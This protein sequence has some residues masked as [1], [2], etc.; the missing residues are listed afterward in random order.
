MGKTYTAD[1]IFQQQRTWRDRVL[2]MLIVAVFGAPA[3]T[4]AAV[5]EGGEASAEG[6]PD[7]LVY[8]TSPYAI[9]VEKSTQRL[10]LYKA[11]S[12]LPKLVKTYPCSTGK[13]RGDKTES[14]DLKTPEGAYFFRM[15]HRDE[16]LPAKYGVMAFVLDFPNYIDRQ[17]GKGGNG[18]WLHGLDKPLLPFDTQGCVAMRNEDITDLSSYIRLYETPVLI[19]ETVN[20]VEP[21]QHSREV[22]EALQLVA[23][24]RKAWQGKDLQ[25]FLDCYSKMYGTAK[26]DQL[27]STK[28][29]LNQR[30]KF[31]SVD[32]HNLNILK[33]GTTLIAGFVQDYESDSFSSAG[34]KKLYL[35]KNS[36]TLKIV[37]ED[38]IQD[39][40]SLNA[41]V[42][43]S[44]ERRICRL[45]NQ[46]VTAWER[47]DIESYIACYASD[48][49]YQRM[50]RL[51][52]KQYKAGINSTTRRITVAV[53]KVKISV[54]GSSA[55][56]SF[57]Q[58]YTSDNHSDYGLKTLDL[59]RSKDGWKIIRETWEPI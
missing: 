18:I 42:T 4:R 14:G 58:R 56:V 20:F 15:L 50:N 7:G 44:D 32:L 51:Q 26:L 23:A 40:R 59:R 35:Q 55:V 1:Y 25:R 12:E 54:N 36:N 8:I 52:W 3:L 45:L 30:Y 46:W 10:Y 2:I 53:D 38:W 16:T 34:F 28:R 19:T 39:A 22:Q 5:S 29:E 21:D 6:I 27:G 13:N 41:G 43:P 49:S 47:K 37:G 24:W 48:F 57:A 11:G 9:V 17:Q 31:I 33:H